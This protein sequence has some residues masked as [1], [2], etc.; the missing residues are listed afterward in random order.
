MEAENDNKQPAELPDILEPIQ[1][2]TAEIKHNRS[3]EIPA[4]YVLIAGLDKE[5]HIIT[6]S[7]FFYPERKYKR[8]YSN[9]TKYLVQ[10]QSLNTYNSINHENLVRTSQQIISRAAAGCSSCGK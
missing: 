7:E 10:K 4:G 3:M 8:Y 5:G 2:I 1:V 9:E 6:G